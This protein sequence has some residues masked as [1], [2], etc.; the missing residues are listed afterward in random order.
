M[1]VT[2]I[3]TEKRTSTIVS[4]SEAARIVNRSRHFLWSS[5]PRSNI[6]YDHQYIIVFNTVIRKQRKGLNS[7]GFVK[8]QPQI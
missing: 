3:D 6:L 1:W 8:K 4:Q 7:K 5:K 2:V